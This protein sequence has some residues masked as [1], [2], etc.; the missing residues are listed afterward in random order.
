MDLTNYQRD[1]N[2]VGGKYYHHLAQEQVEKRQRTKRR[3]P[4]K[5]TPAIVACV[6]AKLRLGWS[7]KKIIG[8]LKYHQTGLPQIS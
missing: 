2:T 5:L 6:D 7:P 4:S 8:W 1:R 3:R